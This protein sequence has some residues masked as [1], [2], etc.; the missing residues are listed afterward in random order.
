MSKYRIEFAKTFNK[1]LSK[2]EKE[3]QKQVKTTIANFL[4]NANASDVIK[5]KGHKDS[6]RI[7]SGSYRII[8]R[9]YDNKLLILFLDVKH[10]K[11]VYRDL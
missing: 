1:S 6:Y 4:N 7:R 5:L 3:T 8:F 10:R 11:E 2:L 9:Q